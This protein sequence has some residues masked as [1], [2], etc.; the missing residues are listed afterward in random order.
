MQPTLSDSLSEEKRDGAR[1]SQRRSDSAARVLFRCHPGPKGYLRLCTETT[2]KKGPIPERS[3]NG[4]A[5]PG[6]VLHTVQID[7]GEW[8]KMDKRGGSRLSLSSCLYNI[9]STFCNAACYDTGER[10]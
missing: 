2:D 4:H 10:F 1:P 6:A 3:G 7:D 8:S 5:A 9:F